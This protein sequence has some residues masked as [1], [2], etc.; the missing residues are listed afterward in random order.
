MRRQRIALTLASNSETATATFTYPYGMA[1]IAPLLKQKFPNTEVFFS[2]NE[3]EILEA[4]LVCCSGLTNAWSQ[5]NKLG[6]KVTAQDKRFIVGGQH[7]TALPHTLKFG[8]PF[9]GPLECLA[10][11]SRQPLPDWTIFPDMHLPGKTHVVMTSRGCPFK[12]RFCSSSAFWNGYYPLPVNRVIAEISE[13]ATLGVRNISI[14]DDLFTVDAKRLKNLVERIIAAGLNSIDFS[15]L[16]RAD[17]VAP[18]VLELLRMMN[19]N[20]VAFGAE[21][22][23][24]VILKMMNKKTTV[25]QNQHCID[26][27]NSFGYIPNSG[28]VIG[29][30]GETPETLALSYEFINKNRGKCLI[31]IFPV[32]P[33][34][35]TW[36]WEFFMQ[37]YSPDLDNFNW[38]SL[39]I[40]HNMA[41][42]ANYH[43][44]TD[45]C[46]VE[47]LKQFCGR[48]QS[49]RF[50]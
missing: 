45:G 35:G 46:T 26:L 9:I 2:L 4:D 21:S 32:H 7:V 25:K 17:S 1:V 8:E 16:V 5:V 44:L 38:S 6:E 41:D 22:G 30:P 14:F 19:V 31:E 18:E 36:L 37:K 15:C 29:F 12:C 40:Q 39:S 43:L 28:I 42:W 24:D 34:P 23:S 27:L 48:A 50:E 20:N 47:D 13:L 33:L 49:L 10:Q 3:R 11:I